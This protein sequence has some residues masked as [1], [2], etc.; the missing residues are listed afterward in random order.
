MIRDSAL[1]YGDLLHQK[2]VD[3]VYD[4][5]TCKPPSNRAGQILPLIF[6]EKLVYL[7]AKNCAVARYDGSRFLKKDI[8]M[9]KRERTDSAAQSWYF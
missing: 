5:M 2:V 9:V 3:Q 4:L 8:C 1:A 7:L 6:I